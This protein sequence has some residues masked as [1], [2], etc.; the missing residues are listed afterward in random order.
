MNLHKIMKQS[1]KF[2]HGCSAQRFSYL[3]ETGGRWNM[4]KTNCNS[5]TAFL[6]QKKVATAASVF[7]KLEKEGQMAS[8]KYLGRFFFIDQFQIVASDHY[9]V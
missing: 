6:T 3:L 5:I 7:F 4:A 9:T 1:K 8:P 2:R